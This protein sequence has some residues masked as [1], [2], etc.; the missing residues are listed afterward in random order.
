MYKYAVINKCNIVINV[1]L[2]DAESSWQPPTDCYLIRSDVASINDLYNKEENSF[3]A[4][5]IIDVPK[6]EV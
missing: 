1:I 6:E 3:T 2:W 5:L 4:P